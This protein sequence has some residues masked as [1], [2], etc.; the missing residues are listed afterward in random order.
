MG[1][2]VDVE[3]PR[4]TL[5]I[6]CAID[7]TMGYDVFNNRSSSS[8]EA[9]SVFLHARSEGSVM[10][11]AKSHANRCSDSSLSSISLSSKAHSTRSISVVGRRWR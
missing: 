5:P 9:C 6:F 8:S 7:L 4:M 2:A 10:T 11:C 3:V 1:S